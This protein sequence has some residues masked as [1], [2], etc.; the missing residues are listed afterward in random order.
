MTDGIISVIKPPGMTSHDVIAVTRRIL[1]EKKAGHCGTLDPQAAGVLPVCLGA[2]TR[3]ADYVTND[4]KGYYGEMLLGAETDTMDA[5]GRKTR[6][7][8]PG[9]HSLEEVRQ[10]AAGLVGRQS[11]EVPAYSAVKVD[12]QALYKKARQGLEETGIY[13]E[14]RI[15]RLDILEVNGPKIR[16][17]VHCGKGTYV[18]TLCRDLAR[19][20]GSGGHMTF[21]IRVQTGAFTLANSVTL[22]ELME[23]KAGILLPK[24]LAVAGLAAIRPEESAVKRIRQGQS[25]WLPESAYFPASVSGHAFPASAGPRMPDSSG[26]LA[27]DV[28]AAAA[29]MERAC[30]YDALGRLAAIGDWSVGWGIRRGQ[31]LFK[32]SKVFQP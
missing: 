29:E 16:F 11:Q 26:A 25:L 8:P 7:Y 19:A 10:A 24:E 28:G 22:E 32:P 14:V 18:R 30:A 13:R 12:G 5:W 17:Y 6:E 21:L 15:Y 31:G 9:R 20:L 2:A 23:K 27:P 1:G 4:S 3:L